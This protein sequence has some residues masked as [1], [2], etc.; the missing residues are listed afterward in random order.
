MLCSIAYFFACTQTANHSSPVTTARV[1]TVC[2]CVCVF[3]DLLQR[4]R[5]VGG[6]RW[7]PQLGGGALSILHD[8]S[9]PSLSEINTD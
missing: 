1:Y 9:R 2:V 4:L 7:Q 5:L 8:E 6:E 3:I